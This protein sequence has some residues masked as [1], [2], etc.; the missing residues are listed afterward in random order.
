M[1]QSSSL[2]S[3]KI[4]SDSRDATALC[5]VVITHMPS[6]P[7]ILVVDDSPDSREML[8]EY[9]RFRGFNVSEASNGEEAIEAARRLRPDLVLMD[10]SMP[11]IDGWEATRQLKA[12]PVTSHSIIIAVSA[13]AFAP[14]RQA[15]KSAGCDAFILKPYDLAVLAETLHD[16]IAKGPGAFDTLDVLTSPAAR[17]SKVRES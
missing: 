4:D 7:A 14:E 9:L 12:D 16:V 10:L 6:S 13:H 8:A 15:A 1:L 5:V 11:G 2:F 3:L 17:A